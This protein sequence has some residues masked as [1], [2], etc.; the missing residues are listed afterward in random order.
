M[1]Y[2]YALLTVIAIRAAVNHERRVYRNVVPKRTNYNV[3]YG[4]RKLP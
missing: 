1:Y 4:G 2:V 3:E